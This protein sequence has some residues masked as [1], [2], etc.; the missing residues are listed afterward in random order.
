MIGSNGH[1]RVSYATED[2]PAPGEEDDG[3]AMGEAVRVGLV[4]LGRM[5][6]FHAANL[7][8]RIPG[9]RLVRVADASEDVAR[10]NAARLGGVEWSTRYEDLLEDP[11]VEAVVIASPT[12]LHAEM[13][14]AGAAAGKHVFCE[15][16]ISQDLERTYDVIEAVRAA[17]V[18]LQVGFQRRFDPDYR[19]A[20]ERI[21]AGHI[22]E[23][24]L[25]RTTLRDVRSPGFDY[26]KGSGGFFADVTVHDF[27]AARWLVGEITEVTAAGAALSDPEF[28]EIG[29]IDNAVITLRFASGALGVM[30][31]S[32][33]AGYGY[34]C[35]SEIVG[36]RGTLR[37]DNHRR[38]AIE[39]L[40][41]GR[42]CRD[43]V[44]DFVER[45]ADAYRQ[46]M[47]HFV[48]VVRGEAEPQPTGTDAAA[49]FVLAR[50]AER[51][52]R[53]GRT[54][55]LKRETRDGEVFYE[56]AG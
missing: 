26:I 32:R 49:A 23:V 41:P 9:V 56:E 55:R 5:G 40:T 16:P 53:E 20:K 7:A 17:G 31:N 6:R 24:Y 38:M 28:E 46:E 45:F 54:V 2:A 25:F 12:H 47:E 4:G 18:K 11:E 14:E 36:H 29:D 10:E 44:S 21:S 27:D 19:A 30:D 48:R 15:K 50:A 3:I 22:G 35:S 34:E 1:Q 51:S 42:A 13:V 52:H 8:G 43:Y 33:V 39:T 37:I